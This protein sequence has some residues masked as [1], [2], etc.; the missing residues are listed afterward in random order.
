M[1]I[2]NFSERFMG[3][4]DVAWAKHANP[5][6]VYTRFTGFP[7]IA[8]VVWS[9]VWIGSWFWVLLAL[10]ICWIWVNPRLFSAPHS[11][12]NWASRGVIG[13][14]LFLNRKTERIA[15]HHIHMGNGLSVVSCLGAKAWFADRMVWVWFDAQKDSS[16]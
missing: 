16:D 9:R 15:R 14:R 13:E 3:M 10:C 5:W 2:Y 7:L 6:A 4:D 12:N 11:L 1:D 8:L